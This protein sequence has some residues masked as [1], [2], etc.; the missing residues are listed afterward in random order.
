MNQFLQDTLKLTYG[1]QEPPPN[2][3]SNNEHS[4]PFTTNTPRKLD[5]LGHDSYPLSMDCTKICVFKQTNKI[6]LSSFLKSKDGM[7]LEPQIRLKMKTNL[8]HN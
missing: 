3:T 2:Q 7:T 5:V 4:C 8:W 1:L 6:G